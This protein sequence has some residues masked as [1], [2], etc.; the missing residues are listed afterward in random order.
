MGF[1]SS[2]GNIIFASVFLATDIM[3]EKYGS[4]HSKKAILLGMISAIIFVVSTQI[5][6]LYIPATQDIAQEKIKK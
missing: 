1:T 5:S 3:T 2:L 6:L 4:E